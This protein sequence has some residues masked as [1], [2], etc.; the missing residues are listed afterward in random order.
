[1]EIINT[2]FH[3]DNEE[4]LTDDVQV[5]KYIHLLTFQLNNYF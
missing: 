3:E 1:M 4:K 5:F 2:I